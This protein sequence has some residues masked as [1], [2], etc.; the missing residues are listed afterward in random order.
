MRIIKELSIAKPI[1]EVW[2]VLGNQFGD[3][4]KWAS[5]ISQSEVSGEAKLP[6]VN[7]SIRKTKTATGDTQQELT[8]FHPEKHEISY[9]S[10]SGT[11]PIIKQVHAHWS[12]KEQGANSTK[13]VLDFKAEMK[14][15]GFI[16][17]PLAKIKLGKVGDVL[18]DDLKHYVE[19]GKPHPRKASAS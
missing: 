8:G 14:G 6:G 15:L 7:Y 1:E 19:N 3:I 12:L 2:E 17:A 16:I 4:Y 18:I 13:L 9:K 11:P 5:I 10:I